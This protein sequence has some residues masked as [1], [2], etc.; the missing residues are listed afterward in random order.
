MP[1]LSIKSLLGCHRESMNVTAP[2]QEYY[3]IAIVRSD[4]TC[5]TELGVHIVGKQI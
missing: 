3:P 4:L 5:P 2:P 1:V